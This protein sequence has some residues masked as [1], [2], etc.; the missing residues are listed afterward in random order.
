MPY[1]RLVTSKWSLQPKSF[2]ET[3]EKELCEKEEFWELLIANA[4]QIVRC[5]D[6]MQSAIDIVK[7]LS[8]GK[9][10]TPLVV[11]QVVKLHKT[12]EQIDAGIFVTDE[13][14]EVRKAC[15]QDIAD[16]REEDARTRACI[17]TKFVQTLR[18]ERE[19]SE[20]RLLQLQE[21]MAELRRPI[22]SSGESGSLVRKGCCCRDW[23]CDYCGE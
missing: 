6:S 18:A 14:E 22:S 17:E 9:A 7:P 11:S 1:Y 15:L 2:S 13:I 16:N 21:D 3:R 10:F 12:P 5:G 4:T 8:Y 20:A 19:E 23:Y